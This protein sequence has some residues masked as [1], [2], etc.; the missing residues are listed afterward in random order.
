MGCELPFCLE[1]PHAEVIARVCWFDSYQPSVCGR[2]VSLGA[3]STVSMVG[4]FR[5]TLIEIGENGLEVGH[6]GGGAHFGAYFGYLEADL[7]VNPPGAV[8]AVVNS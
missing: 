6:H 8:V 2:G 4:D 5:A 3:L 7:F 1:V